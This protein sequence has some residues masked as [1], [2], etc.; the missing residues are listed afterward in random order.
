[1]FQGLDNGYRLLTVCWTKIIQPKSLEGIGV[2]KN[3]V[4][5]QQSG[6][7]GRGILRD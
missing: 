6:H 4:E 1:M 2:Q 3:F 5:N 7:V